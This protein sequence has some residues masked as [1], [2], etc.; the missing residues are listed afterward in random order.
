M[1]V[2]VL[3]LLWLLFSATSVLPLRR[4]VFNATVVSPARQWFRSSL[5]ALS[6]PILLLLLLRKRVLESVFDLA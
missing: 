4:L 5:I 3:L 1:I 2:I 6:L